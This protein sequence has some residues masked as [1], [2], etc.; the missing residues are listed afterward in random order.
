MFNQRPNSLWFGYTS[1][2]TEVHLRSSGKQLRS[3]GLESDRCKIKASS[4]DMISSILTAS[5][6]NTLQHGATHCNTLQHTAS[7]YTAL[8]RTATHNTHLVASTP[9]TPEHTATNCNTLHHTATNCNTPQPTPH[10]SWQAQHRLL[11][12]HPQP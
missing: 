4:S 6:C 12:L 8:H 11:P 2:Y 9:S 5:Y 1:V 7:R 10:T 3:H